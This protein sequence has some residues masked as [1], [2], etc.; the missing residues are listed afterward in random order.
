MLRL[1]DDPLP[2]LTRRARR[3][4]AELRAIRAFV[5]LHQ[6]GCQSPHGGRCGCGWNL[7][8]AAL[9]EAAGD[10]H[11]DRLAWLR[12]T[13]QFAYEDD[14]ERTTAILTQLIEDLR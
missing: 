7:I 4:A 12:G 13:V 1:M 10:A 11:P 8:E 3:L 14:R 2:A 9:E 6:D 5:D